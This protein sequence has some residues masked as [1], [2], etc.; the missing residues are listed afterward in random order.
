M[1]KMCIGWALPLQ[2]NAYKKKSTATWGQS[3]GAVD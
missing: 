3:P 2:L 1:G